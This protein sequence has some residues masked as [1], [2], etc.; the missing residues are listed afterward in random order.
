MRL[1]LS[2]PYEDRDAGHRGKWY[3]V[4]RG[5]Q[6]G[7]FSSWA[8]CEPLVRGF[9]R[10][11]YKSFWT[12]PEARAYVLEGKAAAM[13]VQLKHCRMQTSSFVGGKAL[14]A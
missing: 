14:R 1:T 12:L 5:R 8:Q 2:V 13:N 6:I 9:Q 4:R 3:A 10:A 11:E 7:V